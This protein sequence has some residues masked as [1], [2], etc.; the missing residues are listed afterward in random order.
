MHCFSGGPEEAQRALELGFYLSFGG[1]LTFPKATQVQASAKMAQSDRILLETDA[2]Y[3][4]PVPKRGKRNEPALIIHTAQKLADLRGCSLEE[5]SRLTT[6]NF[7]RLLL[8][9]SPLK[10][11]STGRL[12]SRFGKQ[13]YRTATVR[14]SVPFADFTRET[15]DRTNC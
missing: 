11:Q 9:T 7:H 1:I 3:L 5:V 4:A 12:R 10:I 8:R 13:R 2:P 14:E 6:E 15:H